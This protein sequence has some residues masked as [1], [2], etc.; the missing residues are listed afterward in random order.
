MQ[1]ETTLTHEDAKRALDA[2]ASQ[3][4]SKRLKAVFAVADSH[5]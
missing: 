3:C 1:S 2:M 5:G 4:A